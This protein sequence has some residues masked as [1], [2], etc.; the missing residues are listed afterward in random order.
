VIVPPP[1]T[2]GPVADA[3]RVASPRALAAVSGLVG[4]PSHARVIVASVNM[5]SEART[6]K[7]S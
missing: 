2:D 1:V 3:A 4:V 6:M 5:T 7:P